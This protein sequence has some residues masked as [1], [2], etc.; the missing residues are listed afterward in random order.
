MKLRR[1][2]GPVAVVAALTLSGCGSLSPGNASE[3]E[4]QKITM[5]SVDDLVEAQCDAV[6]ASAQSGQATALPVSDIKRRSLGLLLDTEVS[7]QYAES[8]GVTP[9]KAVVDAI[10]GQ[11]SQA[12]AALPAK[13]RAV[14][15]DA[16]QNWAEGRAG[17]VAVASEATGEEPSPSNLEQ[18]MNAGVAARDEWQKGIDIET[19]PRFSPDASGFPAAG[20]GSVSEPASSFAKSS[21]ATQ[22]DPTWVAT[23]PDSQ[24]C[25]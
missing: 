23:L 4:G 16:L 3:V 1:W 10:Y 2:A 11:F 18:L 21:V 13:P 20:D 24:K 7:K 19:D 14:L 9:D 15:G 8:Q 22:V 6:T 5:S 25:G 12:I 17:L